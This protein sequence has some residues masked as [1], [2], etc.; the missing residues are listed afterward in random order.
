MKKHARLSASSSHRWIN[1]PGSVWMSEGIE[2]VTSDAAE[3]G[4]KAH[5][6][7]EK[8]LQSMN[9]RTRDWEGYNV[10]ENFDPDEFSDEMIDHCEAYVDYISTLGN[11][12]YV[13]QTLDFSVVT[14]IKQINGEVDSFGTC[15]CVVMT[16]DA[17]HIVDF[18]YGLSKVYAKD[19]T[20]LYLYASDY[21][22]I[23]DSHQRVF[24]HIFQP[25]ID[26]VDV[27]EITDEDAEKHIALISRQAKLAAQAFD[28]QK[29]VLNVGDHCR[30]CP[31]K[32]ECKAYNDF[33][34]DGFD[35]I[36]PYKLTNTELAA[37]KNKE[38]LITE[39]F[40]AVNELTLQK[41]VK[42]DKIPGWELG[43]GRQGNRKWAKSP[44]TV[45][46]EDAYKTELC[47]VSE[48]E[49]I[50]PRKDN[51][52]IWQELDQCIGRDPAKQVLVPA[53]T[54]ETEEK[55]I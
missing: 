37:V 52:G 39:Y 51:E 34:F 28:G 19:N 32:G 54:S 2:R 46:G 14:G 5:Y 35:V 41:A 29:P 30:W 55:D 21:L 11:E 8:M 3:E 47:T 27:W 13:E 36:D 48:I 23:I 15:D 22:D 6:L 44:V 18:K 40:R 10:Y 1:C 17:V 45:I 7:A 25:R 9:Y 42:G 20:Q 38:K 53:L 31:A 49:R 16:D 33:V 50:L 43:E 12:I 26:W 4:T 24:C